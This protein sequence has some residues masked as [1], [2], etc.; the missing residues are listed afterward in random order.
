MSDSFYRRDQLVSCR[1]Q[2]TCQW[3]TSRNES[4]LARSWVSSNSCRLRL[5]TCTPACRQA[6]PTC[7]RVPRCS[8][9]DSNQMLTRPPF[10]S[11]LREKPSSWPTNA[12][13]SSEATATSTSTLVDD[14]PGMPSFTTLAEAL[15]KSVS[16][17]SDAS[18]SRFTPSSEPMM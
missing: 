18:Y 10:T 6:E 4:S 2:L 8:M 11:I 9:L 13:K 15:R 5:P 12:S 14:W 1:L 3:T 17:S 16:G 7:T